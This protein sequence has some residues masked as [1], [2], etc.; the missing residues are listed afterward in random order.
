MSTKK[1]GI[2]M[3]MI[4]KNL[5]MLVVFA[6]MFIVSLIAIVFILLIW[7][8]KKLKLFDQVF[9]GGKGVRSP[10]DYLCEEKKL[11]YIAL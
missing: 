8:D 5:V 3:F 7:I 1:E 11:E 6:L 4:V 2:M 9:K 10:A